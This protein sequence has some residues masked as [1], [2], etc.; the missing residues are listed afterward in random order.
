MN[1][2]SKG[3]LYPLHSPYFTINEE[4]LPSG[5]ALHASLAV[6]YL[7]ELSV[8]PSKVKP[9]NPFLAGPSISDF[10]ISD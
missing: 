5:A 9:K 1:D 6:N 3:K 7:S 4:V 2:E 10:P 8:A